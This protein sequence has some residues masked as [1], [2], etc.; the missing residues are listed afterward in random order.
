MK[1]CALILLVIACR[2]ASAEPSVTVPLGGG[3]DGILGLDWARVACVE[4][5]VNLVKGADGRR[6]AVKV[7][8]KKTG[9]E[10]RFLALESVVQGNPGGSKVL[11]VRYRLAL[12]EGKAVRA[13]LLLFQSD[14]GAWFKTTAQPI[15]VGGFQD[16]RMSLKSLR[17]TAFST[18]REGEV[19]WDKVDRACFGLVI[20]GPAKG[21]FE[22]SRV[23]FTNEPYRPTQALKIAY[24]DKALW[25]VSKDKAAKGEVTIDGSAVRFDFSF[26][27]GR[28]MF[29]IPHLRMPEAEL[30]GYTGLRFT[31]KADV[32]DGIKGLLVMLCERG[33]AQYC[34]EP[35][36]QSSAK[37]KTVTIPFTSFKRGSW[38]KDENNRLDLDAIANIGIGVHGTAKAGHAKGFVMVKDVQFVP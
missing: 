19:K 4:A 10:R 21:T 31:Y 24:A 18:D 22:L 12:T 35:P 1:R 5:S 11:A 33:R 23:V 29:D 15:A 16:L 2:T 9:D 32:P 3:S 13:A 20:D 28:H 38:T 25:R 34:A 36:P 37:W 17:P 14:G 7:A 6:S 26:P 30:D 27:G 8:F